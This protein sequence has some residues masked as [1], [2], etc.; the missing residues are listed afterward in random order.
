MPATGAFSWPPTPLWG[1][2]A[3]GGVGAWPTRELRC[4]QLRLF[5]PSSPLSHSLPRWWLRR[6]L[7]GRRQSQG[8]AAKG[9][10]RRWTLELR[11]VATRCRGGLR[12]RRREAWEAL[13]QRHVV[14]AAPEPGSPRPAP[15][16]TCAAQP[17]PVWPLGALSLSLSCWD[18]RVRE[19]DWGQG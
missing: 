5:F 9:G 19:S 13:G 4:P 17:L 1:R 12:R 3:S 16:S 6:R 10:G 11:T 14:P 8:G 2:T 15:G 7:E 18:L